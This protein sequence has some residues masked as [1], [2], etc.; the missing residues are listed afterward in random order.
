MAVIVEFNIE[1]SRSIFKWCEDR[2][3]REGVGGRERGRKI[4]DV[5]TKRL[6]RLHALLSNL[7]KYGNMKI[8]RK[9]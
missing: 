3:E 9:N 1:N 2:R 4:T 8:R 7:F 6:W 5:E